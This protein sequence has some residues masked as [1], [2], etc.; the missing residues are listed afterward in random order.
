MGGVTSGCWERGE[1]GLA[2][3]NSA[4]GVWDKKQEAAQVPQLRKGF[5]FDAEVREVPRSSLLYC[6][7][8]CQ[9][10][11]R[12]EHKQVCVKATWH[13]RRETCVGGAVIEECCVCMETQKPH[14]LVQ[15]FFINPMLDVD[16][17]C[18]RIYGGFYETK[19][20]RNQPNSVKL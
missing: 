4:R 5:T 14:A 15:S 20:R 6:L 13:R 1:N 10:S 19:P 18:T 3:Q 8:G 12:K 7:A 9:A 17:P 2:I 16:P 11:A